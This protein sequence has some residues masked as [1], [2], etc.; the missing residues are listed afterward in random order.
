MIM[1]SHFR[2][3]GP[4]VLEE[5]IVSSAQLLLI[6]KLFLPLKVH[7]ATGIIKRKRLFDWENSRPVIVPVNRMYLLNL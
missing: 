7:S 6:Y 4:E 3:G 2:D 1:T 5:T